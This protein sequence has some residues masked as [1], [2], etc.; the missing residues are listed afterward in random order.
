MTTSVTPSCL[1]LACQISFFVPAAL[2]LPLFLGVEGVLWTGPVADGLAF[3]L[4][5]GLLIHEHNHLKRE[6][7]LQSEAPEIA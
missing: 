5:L 6:H 3:L 4:S 1:S 2:I 7:R